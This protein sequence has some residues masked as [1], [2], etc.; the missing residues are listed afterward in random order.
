[1]SSRL[2]RDLPDRTTV[3]AMAKLSYKE[4]GVRYDMLDAFKRACQRE[5]ATTV[6]QL[7]HRG[8]IEPPHIRGESAY[9]I[10]TPDSYLAHVEEG[11]GS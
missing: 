11:L 7:G 8:F 2:P 10:E 9:L 4:T 3:G 1:M 5:A 6:S